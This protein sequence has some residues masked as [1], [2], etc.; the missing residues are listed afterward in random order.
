MKRLM[1][2]IPAI[3]LLAG[4]G[5]RPPIEGRLDPYE[6]KQV[7]FDSMSLKH[8]TAVGREDPRGATSS[9]DIGDAIRRRRAGIKA[10]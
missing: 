6:A 9:A 7:H 2:I 3:A 4:C 1:I 8:E 5:V 10:A